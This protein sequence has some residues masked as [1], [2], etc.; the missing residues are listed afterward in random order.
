MTWCTCWFGVMMWQMGVVGG[1]DMA[2]AGPFTGDV[3]VRGCHWQ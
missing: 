1:C 3:A 2:Y